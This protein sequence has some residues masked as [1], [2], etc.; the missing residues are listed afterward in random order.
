MSET[1]SDEDLITPQELRHISEEK[2]MEE[3]RAALEQQKKLEAQQ[4][5][6]YQAFMNQHI[7]PDAKERFTAAVR[8]AAERGLNEIQLLRFPSA[9]CTDGGRAINN[10]DPD[11]SNSLTGF[12]KEAF[13]AWDQHLRPSGYKLRAQIL[14]Y[15]GGMPGDVGIF[16]RW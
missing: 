5:D 7:R 16:L 6:L 15:P 14:N 11:W 9:F 10:F 1:R 13:D 3:I 8:R 2:E 4:Q 12:A